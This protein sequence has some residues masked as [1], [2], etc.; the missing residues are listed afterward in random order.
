MKLSEYSRFD[1]LALAKFVRDKQVAPLDLT[2]LAIEAA[3]PL[4][5]RLNAIWPDIVV[6]NQVLSFGNR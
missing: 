5:A 4:N 1:G 3:A 2:R 6:D